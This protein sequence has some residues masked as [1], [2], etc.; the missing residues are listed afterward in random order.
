[1]SILMSK[2]IVKKKGKLVNKVLI[3]GK[4]KNTKQI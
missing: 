3:F 2:Q 1:M 4:E